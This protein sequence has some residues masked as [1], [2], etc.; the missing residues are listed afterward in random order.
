MQTVGLS[1]ATQCN[2]IC[3][4]WQVG[5]EVGRQIDRSFIIVEI[6]FRVKSM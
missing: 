6:N 4:D 1:Y 2:F 3:T 5:R